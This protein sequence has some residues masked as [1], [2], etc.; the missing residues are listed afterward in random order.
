M[1]NTGSATRALRTANLRVQLAESLRQRLDAG[2]WKVGQQLPTETEL[3]QEY[4]VSRSTVR[5][6]LQ[7]LETQGLTITK[8][9]VGTFV[10]P[11]GEAIKAGLQ[12]LRSMTDT[13]RA[14]SMEPRMDY[15]SIKYRAATEEEAAALRLMASEQVLATKRAVM[16]DDVIVAYSYEAIPARLLPADLRPDQVHGSL[17]ALLDASGTVPRT[18]VAD[19]HAASGPE[20]GWGERDPDQLYVYLRQVHFDEHAE[21]VVFSQTYF[22]EGRFEFSV[23]RVR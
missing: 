7:Q 23:L 13:I 22:H 10:S 2:E 4:G 21:P 17:F 6:S 20:I 8:H 3:A 18:A 5:S 9:G 16:A 11:Y 15:E 14:H 12:E 19:I 1:A